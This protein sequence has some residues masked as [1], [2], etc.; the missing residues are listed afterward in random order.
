MVPFL[1]FIEKQ[2]G[3][4]PLWLCPLKPGREDKLSPNIVNTDMVINVGVWGPIKQ[5]G[6]SFTHSNKQLEKKVMEL[7]GRKVLYAHCYYNEDDFW[8][9]YDKK[10][11]DRLRKKYDAEIVFPDVFSKTST[12]LPKFKPSKWRGFMALI[13]SPYN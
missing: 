7:G 2:Y 8:R 9:V 3:I 1:E 11:Y 5:P 13:S 4:F 6:K 10:Y 12:P